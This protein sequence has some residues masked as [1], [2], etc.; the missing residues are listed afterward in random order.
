MKILSYHVTNAQEDGIQY[1][2]IRFKKLNLLVGNSATGKTRLLNTIFNLAC[3]VVREN[4]FRL[5]EWKI[6]FEHEGKEYKW[7]I[8]SNKDQS[9]AN[10]KILKEKLIVIEEGSEHILVDRNNDSF[11]FNGA[12]LPKLS[13]RK[14]SI[15]L[16]KEEELI[17][18]VFN[19]FG[20]ILRRSFHGST[21]EFESENMILPKDRFNSIKETRDLNQLF[22]S[23]LNLNCRLYILSKVFKDLY[24]EICDEFIAVFPFVSTVKI[25]NA[26]DFGMDTPGEVPIFAL[27]EK[28]NNHWIQLS[29]LSSGMKKVLLIITDVYT[30]PGNGAVYLIDEYENSLGINAIN[31]FPSVLYNTDNNSQFIITSHHPY[32]IGNVPVSNWIL[33]N[34]KGNIVGIKQGDQLKE[35]FG[36]SKQESFMQLIND[37]F[38]TEGIE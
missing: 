16:L 7:H 22:L 34:R 6:N 33:L 15:E 35:K 1:P 31:F 36:K 29:Q 37:P 18:P 3:L 17:K 12:N 30:L 2:N 4:E 25:L 11:K 10:G 32:I 19:A 27:K 14:T 23:G 8:I 9:I 20:L 13:Q 38:Y 5:G 24:K 21:L 26:N 28:F